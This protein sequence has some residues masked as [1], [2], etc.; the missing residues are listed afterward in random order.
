M[1][2]IAI[3]GLGRIG[4]A[5]LKL[6]LTNPELEVVA[7]NDLANADNLAYLM[8]FDSVYRRYEHPVSIESSNGDAHLRIGNQNVLLFQQKDAALLP[9]RRLN[10]DIVVESTGAYESYEQSRV[11]IR[12][13]AKR[14]VL[15]APAKDDDSG[16]AQTILMGVNAQQIES[17]ALSSNGSCTTNSV[18]PAL[19]ILQEK[20]GISKAMLNT[21][22]GYT[23]T[24][25]LVDGPVRGRDMRRGRAG[26][27]NIVPSRT[28]AAL[29]VA[30]A[31]PE[32]RGRFDGVAMRV[33][34]LIGS[35]SAI[36]FVSA[37]PTTVGEINALLA[38]AAATPRWRDI[39]SVTEEALVSADIIGDP[40][41][42]IVD[43]SLTRVVDGDL[44]CI[45]SW[46]DNEFGFTNTLLAHVVEAARTIATRQNAA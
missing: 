19:Q 45:Y 7:A 15:T 23:A 26:A 18:A 17:C 31:I 21:V 37:R 29:A 22:H 11:H 33:P 6:A 40:H 16:D 41:A 38:N 24:Q 36:S 44:C 8:R 43:L 5:F 28:G 42:A 32:L 25:N 3:N 9:W 39:L 13:G 1:A 35:L 34:V 30:R 14:V 12:A 46:Y 27:A 2:K 4:R 10:V 20:L